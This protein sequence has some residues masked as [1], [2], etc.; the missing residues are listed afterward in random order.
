[1]SSMSLL[2]EMRMSSTSVELM[3]ASIIFLSLKSGTL[4]VETTPVR[5]ACW[6]H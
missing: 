5:A 3:F 1:M 4:G 6:Q 2:F